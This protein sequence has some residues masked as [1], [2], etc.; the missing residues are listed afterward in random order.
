MERNCFA[1][2]ENKH[3]HCECKVLK[4]LECKKG[5]KDCT[6]YKN[7][8]IVNLDKIEGDILNY[9]KEKS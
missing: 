2:H 7:R 8:N 4:E 6:F 3:N 5:L 9:A 1:F